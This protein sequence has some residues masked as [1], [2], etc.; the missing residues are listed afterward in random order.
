MVKH[1]KSLFFLIGLLQSVHLLGQI[2]GQSVY[3]FVNLPNSSRVLALGSSSIAIRDDDVNMAFQNPGLINPAM[4]Q[5][6][7][8]SFV[9]YFSGINFGNVAYAFNLKK[10]GTASAGIQ[11][12]NY[13]KFERADQTGM[14]TGEFTAGEYCLNTGFGKNIDSLFTVGVNIK[15]IFSNLESYNSFGMAIDAGASYK[16]RN[17]LF[18]MGVVMKNA[19]YQFVSYY[20]GNHERLPFEL[21][22]GLSKKLAHMPLRFSLVAHNLQKPDLTFKDPQRPEVSIDPLSGDTVTKKTGIATKIMMHGILGAE[23]NITK[24]ILFRLG[25]NYQRRQEMK[26]DT[27]LKMVGFSWGLG[28]RVYKFSLDYSRS[29]YHL[30]GSPNMFTLSAKLSEFYRRN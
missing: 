13:G 23:L 11:Y 16:S 22:F 5:R 2:G 9:D 19:G 20:E 10:W 29:A 12:I 8:L 14:I 15:T 17:K 4:N 21:Q 26:V 28:I 3:S 1:L 7:S 24:N 30:A 18:E 6:L 27:R 25:Y